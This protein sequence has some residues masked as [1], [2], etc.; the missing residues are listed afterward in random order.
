MTDKIVVFV[1]SSGVRQ[2]RKIARVLVEE[3]LAACANV[4]SAVRSIY[5]W[6][7]KVAEE[8]ECLMI[9]KT[10]RDRFDEVRAS[11]ERLHSYSVPEVIALPIVDG[12][13]NYLAWLAESTHA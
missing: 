5:R 1:T 7:G 4:I 2:A 13:P 6:E 12:A 11:V 9:I 10:T 8:N 3:K